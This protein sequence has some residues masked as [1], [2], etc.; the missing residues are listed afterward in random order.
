MAKVQ[1]RVALLH[2][3]VNTVRCPLHNTVGTDPTVYKYLTSPCQ[4]SSFKFT[5]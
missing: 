2:Y 4:L 5:C 1:Q 3:I